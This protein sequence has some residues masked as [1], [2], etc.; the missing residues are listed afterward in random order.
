MKKQLV[1]LGI[2]AILTFIGLSGCNSNEQTNET[3]QTN[4]QE[5]TSEEKII[6]E[7]IVR[8]FYNGTFQSPEMQYIFYSNGTYCR[9]ASGITESWC[10]DY[11]LTGN[12]STGNKLI[13]NAGSGDEEIYYYSFY[14]DDQKIIL[15][16]KDDHM[17]YHVFVRP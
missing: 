2:V 6:G 12:Q 8:T 7:W 10:S 17:W 3:E 11:V 14:S 13:L 5:Q 9:H 15:T 4:E 16:D 1:I